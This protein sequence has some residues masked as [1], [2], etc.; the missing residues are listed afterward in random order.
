MKLKE[1]APNRVLGGGGGKAAESLFWV[2]WVWG[3]AP[4][5]GAQSIAIAPAR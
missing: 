4:E 5:G 1:Q 2:P 3:L